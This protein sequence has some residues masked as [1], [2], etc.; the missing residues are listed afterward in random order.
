M[1]KAFI[2]PIIYKDDW[3]SVLSKLII[4]LLI[5]TIFKPLE[6]ATR[7]SSL[8]SNSKPTALE[9]AL[10]DGSIQFT[11]GAFRG[12][13]NAAISKEIKE[14][15]GKFWKGAW[16]FVSP[17]LP[18]HLQQ[19]INDNKKAMEILEKNVEKAIDSMPKEITKMIKNMDVE[20]LGVKTLDRQSVE[21]KEV[22][23]RS[24]AVMPKQTRE[25]KKQLRKEYLD[26]K[27]KP[28][29]RGESKKFEKSVQKSTEEFA[30]ETVAQ[31]RRDTKKI[32]LGGKSREEIR[33][34]ID[35]RLEVGKTRAKF[36]ARQ[37]TSLLTVEFQ[38]IQYQEIEVDKY[39]WM[40]VGDHI[41]RGYDLTKAEKGKKPD[42]VSLDGKTFSWDNPPSADHFSTGTQCH[43]GEDYN[44]RCQAK[45]IVEW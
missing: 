16:R 9:K 45:P 1:G 19:A 37:E 12:K 28:I 39:E 7:E 41:V 26:V 42:H 18:T 35:N 17:Q 20:S 8:H 11:R 32:I 21:F 30:F 14:L 29:K 22:L 34:Y 23:N 25:G 24:L 13:I 40:T 10:R 31:L 3:H 44:C 33:D 36:I 6:E 15:G 27:D 5:K 4:S 43:P 2:R 38:K